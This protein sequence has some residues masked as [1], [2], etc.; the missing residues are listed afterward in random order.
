MKQMTTSAMHQNKKKKRMSTFVFE[1]YEADV[2]IRNASRKQNI[3]MKWMS[4]S[5]S[6]WTETDL[7]IRNGRLN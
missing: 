7:D 1:N 6:V 4:T 2:D 3:F 5:V